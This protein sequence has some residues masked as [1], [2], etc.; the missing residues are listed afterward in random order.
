M[1]IFKRYYTKWVFPKNVAVCLYDCLEDSLQHSCFGISIAFFLADY[2]I[3][4]I[5]RFISKVKEIQCFHIADHPDVFTN[6]GT[7]FLSTNHQ[8]ELGISI[9]PCS[10]NMLSSK[11]NEH[12][13]LNFLIALVLE[14]NEITLYHV[15]LLR[16]LNNTISF[17][18]TVDDQ[19][20]KIETEIDRL[21]IDV[22]D[23]V[24]PPDFLGESVC[25]G[26][27]WYQ[28]KHTNP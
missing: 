10:R 26:S 21:N 8:T 12:G 15:I 14:L 23:L 20:L 24:I 2:E 6:D 16:V 19:L 7:D 18:S 22:D 28:L 1:G 5:G 27:G 3:K 4:D 11:L 25:K 17:I 9:E 13:A